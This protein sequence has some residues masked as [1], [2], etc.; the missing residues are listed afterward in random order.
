MKKIII[1]GLF[2]LLPGILS[3]QVLISLIFG[4]KL[5]GENLEFGLDVGINYASLTQLTPSTRGIIGLNLGMTFLVKFSEDLLLNPVLYYVFPC[6]SGKLDPYSVG[7]PSLDPLLQGTTVKR[8]LNGF[9]LPVTL[10]YRLFGHTF[11]ELGPQMNLTTS[12]KDTFTGS[13]KEEEDFTYRFD[14][15]D[16]YRKF[17]TGITAGIAQRFKEEKGITLKL[18]YY[19]GFRDLSLDPAATG[20]HNSVIYFSVSVPVGATE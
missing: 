10:R 19:Y 3:A 9:S 15:K 6:G 16:R 17:D 1:A 20:Q 11:I 2:L 18:R 12:A 4:D 14:I 5:N 8:V 13:I 7:E